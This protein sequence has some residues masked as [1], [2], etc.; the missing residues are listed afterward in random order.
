[1]LKTVDDNILLFQYLIIKQ[2]NNNI[3][4]LN[5]SLRESHWDRNTGN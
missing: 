4:L 3:S 5:F 1:M 2:R